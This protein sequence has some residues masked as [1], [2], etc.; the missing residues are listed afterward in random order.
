M[1]FDG[2]TT[3]VLIDSGS[4]SNLMG[5]KEYEELDA[6]GLNAKLEK[7]HKQLYGWIWWQGVG[8]DG[9]D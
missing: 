6:Q 1:S 4:V 9:S 8:S 5:M 3:V 2:V 7:C